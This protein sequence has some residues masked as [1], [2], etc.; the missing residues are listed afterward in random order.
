MLEG[1]AEGRGQAEASFWVRS[2]K[3]PKRSIAKRTPDHSAAFDLALPAMHDAGLPK[4]AAVGHRVVHG[5]PK[6]REHVLLNKTV[7]EDLDR[8]IPFAPLHLPASLAVIDAALKA[9]PDIAQGVC[10][11]TTFHKDLPDVSKTLPLSAEV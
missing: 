7:R 11:D 10:L 9:M 5:G 4:L 1:E 2:R 8:A 6:L 3:S